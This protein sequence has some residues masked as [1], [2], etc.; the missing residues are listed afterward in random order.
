MTWKIKFSTLNT[1]QRWEAKLYEVCIRAGRYQKND[2]GTV[3]VQNIT[4][5]LN[6]T[7]LHKSLLHTLLSL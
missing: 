3:L 7:V 2:D 4:V 1:S 5:L 6:I